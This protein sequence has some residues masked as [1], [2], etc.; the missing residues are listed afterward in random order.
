MK[1]NLIAIVIGG[2]LSVFASPVS[3]KT[4]IDIYGTYTDSITNVSGTIL[5]GSKISTLT[6]IT[7]PRSACPAVSKI[8]NT[9]TSTI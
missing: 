1:N 4:F 8:R 2:A 7:H 3:A 5:S 9:L 6:S